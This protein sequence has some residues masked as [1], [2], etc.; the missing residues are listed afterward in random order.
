MPILTA[1]CTPRPHQSTLQVVEVEAQPMPLGPRNPHGVGFDVVERVL[2]SEQE[3]QRNCAPERS[4]VWK[5]TC[6][7]WPTC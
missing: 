6:A 4:R 7:C 1:A 5:V 3:A 2:E